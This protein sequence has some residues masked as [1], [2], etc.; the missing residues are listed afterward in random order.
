MRKVEKVRK[1]KEEKAN[2]ARKAGE[3][4]EAG[5]ERAEVYPPKPLAQAGAA[6]ASTKYGKR[7]KTIDDE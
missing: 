4:G 6:K 7:Y 2:K 1:G 5:E 3:A